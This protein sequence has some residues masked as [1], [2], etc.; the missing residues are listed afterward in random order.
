MKMP[1]NLGQDIVVLRTNHVIDAFWGNNGWN[2]HARFV[3]RNT[4]KGKFL[5]Q[6]SGETVPSPVFKAILKS[7]GV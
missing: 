3:L 2:P 6:T 5:S 7:V 4:P 1:H